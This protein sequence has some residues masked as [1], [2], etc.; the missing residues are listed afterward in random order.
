[1]Y[2]IK[3]NSNSQILAITAYFHS[4]KEISRKYVFMI[5][6]HNSK[7]VHI[8]SLHLFIS[9]KTAIVYIDN[10]KIVVSPIFSLI[11]KMLK[12]L[13]FIWSIFFSSSF[14]HVIFVP[15]CCLFLDSFRRIFASLFWSLF[16]THYCVIPIYIIVHY[17]LRV[18]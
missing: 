9:K 8:F 2:K 11:G 5:I 13:C 3:F 12:F 1:M 16:G 7:N 4:I 10:N 14:L 6:V 18:L 15:K 17:V